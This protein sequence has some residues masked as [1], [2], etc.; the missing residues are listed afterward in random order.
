MLD[1]FRNR[2]LSSVIYGV[3]IVAT[4][5]V[6]VI[7]F[8]PSAG[9]KTASIGEQC[10]A[11]VRGWC[12]TPK[13]HMAAY[14]IL[15]PRGPNGELQTKRAQQMGL[16][17]ISLDGLVERELL[18]TEAE[19]IGI[20]VTDDEVTDEIFNGWIHVSVPSDNPGLAYSLR[21]SE[22]RI[23][24]GFRDQKTK[25]FDL[26]VYERTIKVL[27]GRSPSDFREE[28]I[29][30]LVAA[31][32]RDLVRAPVRVSE[33]DAIESYI[34]EKSTATVTYVPVKQSYVTRYAVTAPPADV[35]AWAKDK[36]NATLV[37]STV[38]QRKADVTP[39][40]GHI[41]HILVK[42]AP[43]ASA[44]DKALALGKLARAVQRIKAGEL[45]ADVAH[46]VSDDTGSAAHGG[47]VGDKTDG[48]VTPFK[49]AADAL[50]PGEMT[51]GAVETQFG[52]HVIVKDD[53]SKSADVEAALKRDVARELYIKTKALDATKSLA[54][55]VLADIKAGKSADDA[56][57]AALA[58]LDKPA[59]PLPPLAVL[60]DEAVAPKPAPAADA[61]GAAE[62]G[63][64]APA[65]AGM[66]TEAG[67]KPP[68]PPA[69]KAATA[70]TDP[71][72]PQAMTSS[73]FNKGGDTIP[74]A[75]SDVDEKVIKFAFSAKDGDVLPEVLRTDDGYVVVQ[76]KQHKLATKEEFDKER[77]TYLST[78]LAAKQAEALAL[79][80]MRLRET[81]KAEI[82]K[83]EKYLAEKMPK[84]DGGAPFE[85]DDDE[86][87]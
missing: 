57:K 33:P 62:G 59:P 39:K 9:K 47:D 34:N 71:D 61:G 27:M 3:I 17:N 43:T 31:K 12:I 85:E 69:P 37:D 72:H 81:A 11:R 30:E 15:I 74:D 1:V 44:D 5:L 41:R 38:T 55:R 2:G 24:A 50:K 23:Y 7:Q 19:R 6:F 63:A 48:F 76:L 60:G 66:A 49:K 82:K 52:Y 68:V 79:Y 10:A 32:M 53:P 46:E 8:N 36:A 14:R 83:D 28:Q 35:D 64:G 87:P 51:S 80:V 58:P 65:D 21:V 54:E 45:F 40:E 13:D 84:T 42:V 86:G 4:I 77:D 73:S 67:A 78:L 75:P 22:G 25:R 26:K 16:I 56:A 29:R 18:V 20:T 70:L